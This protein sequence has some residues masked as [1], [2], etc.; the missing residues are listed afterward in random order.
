MFLLRLFSTRVSSGV[1]LHATVTVR[2][3]GRA[4]AGCGDSPRSEAGPAMANTRAAITAPTNRSAFLISPCL[5][6]VGRRKKG[7]A[8]ALACYSVLSVEAGA[9]HV[10]TLG[11]HFCE[12]TSQN[13]V[14]ANFREYLF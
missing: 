14:N 6:L 10:Y 4:W 3:G 2:A 8:P 11:G 9:R 7:E 5:S 13:A 12:R 1:A